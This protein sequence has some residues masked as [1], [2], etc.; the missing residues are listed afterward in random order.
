MFEC[1][2]YHDDDDDDDRGGSGCGR[3]DAHD[4]NEV[5]EYLEAYKGPLLVRD[6]RINTTRKVFWSTKAA[7]S[8]ICV[9]ED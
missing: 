6:N 7:A 2:R 4:G 5:I 3:D 9:F 8:Q 1:N